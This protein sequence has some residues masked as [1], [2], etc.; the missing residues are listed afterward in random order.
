MNL[1]TR[2]KPTVSI[3]PLQMLALFYKTTAGQAAFKRTY[4]SRN[5]LHAIKPFL[6]SLG[7]HYEI[8]LQDLVIIEGSQALAQKLTE[9]KFKSLY[10]MEHTDTKHFLELRKLTNDMFI[11]L[12]YQPEYN[13][14][15]YIIEKRHWP[16]VVL[17]KNILRK[18]GIK[19]DRYFVHFMHIFKEVLNHV[20]HV[21]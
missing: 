12:L 15:F 21:G 18:L 6:D 10:E 4:E 17:T 20:T 5:Q 16:H 8:V 13:F 9:L 3:N 11:Q 2:T 1:L 14:E 19:A 7:C